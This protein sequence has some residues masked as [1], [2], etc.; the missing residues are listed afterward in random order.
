MYTIDIVYIIHP[1]FMWGNY[2]YYYWS[3]ALSGTI[4]YATVLHNKPTFKKSCESVISS[5]ASVCGETGK[6]KGTF[7][8][9]VSVICCCICS[10][11]NIVEPSMLFTR[12]KLLSNSSPFD[13]TWQFTVKSHSS[14]FVTWLGSPF[15]SGRQAEWRANNVNSFYKRKMC[16]PVKILFHFISIFLKWRHRAELELNSHYTTRHYC[17]SVVHARS[18]YGGGC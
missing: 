10:W 14:L 3:E 1:I 15:Y 9:N 8:V 5:P 7:A 6:C 13:Y 2:Y 4:L 17:R 11:R 16:G 18:L 12:S